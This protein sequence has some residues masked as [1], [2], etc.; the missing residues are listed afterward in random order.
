MKFFVKI[1][2]ALKTFSF[3][4]STFLFCSFQVLKIPKDGIVK[5]RYPKKNKKQRDK[6]DKDKTQQN[7]SGSLSN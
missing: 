2:L 7:S 6:D 1:A 3:S 4:A 5:I